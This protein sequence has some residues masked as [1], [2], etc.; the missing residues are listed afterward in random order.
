MHESTSTSAHAD[1]TR[2]ST[3]GLLVDDLSPSTSSS[4]WQQRHTT[5]SQNSQADLGGDNNAVQGSG[6]SMRWTHSAESESTSAASAH[7]SQH[8]S[9]QNAPASTGTHTTHHHLPQTQQQEQEQQQEQQQASSTAAAAVFAVSAAACKGYLPPTLQSAALLSR[10][11]KWVSPLRCVLSQFCV[12]C[13]EKRAC[14]VCCSCMLRVKTNAHTNNALLLMHAQANLS[15]HLKHSKHT[16][17]T[18][19]LLHSLRTPQPLPSSLC[20]GY[21]FYCCC[22]NSLISINTRCSCCR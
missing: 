17:S 22:S 12:T 3:D 8:S 10:P 7:S 1:S 9:H 2:L 19:G 16:H 15:T 21:R 5:P 4:G 13:V 6:H 18:Q 14:S 11:P 20:T